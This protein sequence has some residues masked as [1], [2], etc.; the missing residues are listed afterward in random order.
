[1]EQLLDQGEAHVGVSAVDTKQKNIESIPIYE[2]SVVFVMP[3]DAYDEESGPQI[4]IRDTL[5]N[6]YL[7]TH[8]HP[9][10]WDDLLLILNQ[11]FP[12][13]RTMKVT[14]AHIAKRFVQEGLGISFLPHSIVRR[15]LLEGRLM[16]PHFDLFELPKVSAY[17]HVKRKGELEEAFIKEISGYHFV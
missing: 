17:V 9:S 11:E 5:M 10:Y 2:E 15:E 1:I 16:N 7:F 3:N 12:G 4:D 14:Q 6:H 13:I 8:H